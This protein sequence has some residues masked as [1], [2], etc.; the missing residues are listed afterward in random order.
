VTHCTSL[1]RRVERRHIR[2]RAEPLHTEN[3]LR[4]RVLVMHRAL[5]LGCRDGV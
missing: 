2:K 1:A 5:L 3:R 4:S